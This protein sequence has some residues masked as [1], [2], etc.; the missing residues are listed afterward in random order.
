M[1]DR[2]SSHGLRGKGCQE[3]TRLAH[4][5]SLFPVPYSL[6]PVAGRTLGRG[7]RPRQDVAWDGQRTNVVT[8]KMDEQSGN[9]Y[10]NKGPLWKTRVLCGN[11]HENTGT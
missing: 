1:V 4:Y 3:S 5:Y 10:E 6:F 2:L 7:S 8:S 9:V 11:V